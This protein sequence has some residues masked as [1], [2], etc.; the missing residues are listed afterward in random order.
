MA[1]Y[2]LDINEVTATS[3]AMFDAIVALNPDTCVSFNCITEGTEAQFYH[4]EDFALEKLRYF[5]NE[6]LDQLCQNHSD[7]EPVCPEC[8]TVLKYEISGDT[9][10]AERTYCPTCGYEQ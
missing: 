10:L 7:E 6:V 8:S 5:N 3:E 4:D 1:R 9:V 2:I